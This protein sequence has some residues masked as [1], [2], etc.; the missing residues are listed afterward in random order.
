MEQNEIVLVDTSSWIEAL[1]HSGDSDIRSRVQKLMINGLAAWCDMVTIE[2]WNGAIGSYEKEKLSELENEILC[3]PIN[4]DVWD[5]A[6]V[7]TKECRKAGKTVP[8][9]DLIIT[10]CAIYH[11]AVLEHHDSHIDFILTVYHRNSSKRNS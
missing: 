3:L 6:R 5:F 10:S 7:L 8:P 1:R 11:N 2:L 4:K 9:A